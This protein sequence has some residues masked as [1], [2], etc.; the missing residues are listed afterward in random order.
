M[1]AKEADQ[2]VLWKRR[3]GMA[4]GR[5]SSNAT[6]A[7]LSVSV[8]AAAGGMV[9]GTMGCHTVVPEG[10]TILAGNSTGDVKGNGAEFISF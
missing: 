1:L 8:T 4:A 3:V 6:C 10:I 2:F 5:L 9:L 7:E